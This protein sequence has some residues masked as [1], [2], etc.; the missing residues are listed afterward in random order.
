MYNGCK[1]CKNRKVGCHSECEVYKSFVEENRILK[2]NK[3]K[4]KEYKLFKY[5]GKRKY[6]DIRKKG[7]DK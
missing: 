7:A 3:E 4:E 2:E 6:S 5:S 1:D